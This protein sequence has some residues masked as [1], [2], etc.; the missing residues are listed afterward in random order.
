MP[1]GDIAGWLDNETRHQT[2]TGLRIEPLLLPSQHSNMRNM[3]P[4]RRV[5]N[6][7]DEFGLL[8]HVKQQGEIGCGATFFHTR[9]KGRDE[10]AGKLKNVHW[11]RGVITPA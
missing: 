7:C 9:T 11:R 3:P 4:G 6:A 2:E 10:A 1:T 8:L 5:Q